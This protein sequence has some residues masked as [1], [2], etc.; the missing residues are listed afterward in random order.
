MLIY[1]L[2]SI[3]FSGGFSWVSLFGAVWAGFALLVIGSHLYYLIGVDEAKQKALDEIR[4]EKL[5][6]WEL[7]WPEEQKS[8]K[9]I[10]RWITARAVMNKTSLK[11]TVGLPIRYPSGRF[12]V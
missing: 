1:A 12:C 8:Q 6:Q 4:K 9:P 5:R 3:S 10:K 2:P 7:K 11:D